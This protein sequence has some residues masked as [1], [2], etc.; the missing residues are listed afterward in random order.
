MLDFLEMQVH[1]DWT[2][3]QEDPDLQVL[4]VMLV[5]LE[6]PAPLASLELKVLWGR[7]VSQAQVGPREA[8]VSQDVQASPVSQVHLGSQEPRE[9]L[10]YQEWELQ[11][12]QD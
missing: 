5:S 11:E 12:H 1:Q 8:Q 9:T 2:D 4:R 6:V 7:W 10:E 3:D